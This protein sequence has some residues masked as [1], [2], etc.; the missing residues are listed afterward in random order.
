MSRVT[1]SAERRIALAFLVSAIA[2]CSYGGGSSYAP[3]PP[4]ASKT[5][6]GVSVSFKILIPTPVKSAIS[7]P[8]YVSPSTQSVSISVNGGTP[9]VANL[10]PTSSGCASVS[11]GTQCTVPMTAPLGSDTFAVSTF[12]GTNA[13]GNELSTASVTQTIVAGQANT[14]NVTL[15]GVVAGIALALQ[16]TP[17]PEGSAATV[18]ISVMAKDADGN[19]IV[20]PGS[21]ENAI[22][23]ADADTSGTTKLSTTT[24]S[25][26]SAAVTL[27]YSGGA[28]SS[29]GLNAHIT[30][31]S[32]N[33]SSSQITNVYFVTAQ[34]Q[35]VTWGKSPYR[36]SYNPTE[37]TLTQSNVGGLKL[38]WQTTL[39]GVIT[40]EPIVVANVAGTSEGPVDVL[41]VGDA[42]ADIYAINAGT[43]KVLWTKTLQS[44][45]INGNSSDPAQNGCFDQPGGV[46]GIG[47][48][49]VA[50][51]ARNSVYAVDGMGYIYG[52]NLATGAQQFQAGPLW[53]YDSSDNDLNITNSYSALNE[54]VQHDVIYAPGSA[55]C[56]NEN[57]G[58][59]QQYNIS[60]GA[61]T[62]WYTM[63]GPPNFYGGI[64]GPGGVVI[65]PRE[66][67]DASDDNVFF[68]TAYGPTP[69]GAGQYPYSIVRL[70]ENMT[71]NS[72]SVNPIDATW[73]AD[74]DFGDTPLVFAPASSSGCGTAML[75]AAE[76]KNGVLYLFNADNLDAG[77][78]QT[79]QL[80]K[81]SDDGVNLGSP[82]YD[83]TRNLLYINN[84]SDSSSLS[85]DH[86]L[87]AFTLTSSCQLQ[88]AW[89]DTIGPDDE[90]DGPPSP[91]TVA[92]GVVY[93]ADGPGSDCTPVGNSGCGVTTSDFNAYNAS[94]GAMLFHT[95]V[96]G[97]LFTPPVVVNGRVYI[98]SWDGQGP[99]I[100]YCF[101]L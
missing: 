48:S 89:Q 24:V 27:S 98:T 28:L 64:W 60:S 62:H 35:W 44:E 41:Y 15:D 31:S 46:Y 73:P 57:Y 3:S 65:D 95:T 67:S 91:P 101:G 85:I 21:Y 16:S 53:A 61:I 55:H 47:G 32:P 39:G 54:D 9:V 77:P 14:V 82:A 22:S 50:D 6:K 72:A 66:A 97:P 86:G 99:G 56:G 51:P 92:N 79:V 19:T 17:P 43:G 36:N 80:G 75:L 40:G 5:S 90:A 100:V 34:D 45:T 1:R 30:A 70:N 8:Q 83:P 33:V 38:L 25:A 18:G 58:G 42:H 20:G 81:L 23:L 59:V 13:T 37:T 4:S 68:G 10:S 93:Y 12:D 52:F 78:T 2:G 94:S 96:G 87:V 11:G 63:G 7:R 29:A 49:P 88:L 69:P 76:S 71:V 84:G 26:P 74:L